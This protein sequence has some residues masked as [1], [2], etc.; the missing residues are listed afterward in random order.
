M[1]FFSKKKIKTDSKVDKKTQPKRGD[2]AVTSKTK[3]Q[4][5]KIKKKTQTTNSGSV[6]SKKVPQKSTQK[7]KILKHATG[8]AYLSLTRPIIT[9][10]AMVLQE[11]GVYTFEVPINANKIMIKKAIK[12]LYGFMPVRVNIIKSKGKRKRYG[13]SMGIT[14]KRKKALVYLKKGEKIEFSKK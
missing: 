12:E 1:L 2:L 10:K 11:Q 13:K 9:E 5:T 3:R 4:S 8:L 14:K 7:D 6:V